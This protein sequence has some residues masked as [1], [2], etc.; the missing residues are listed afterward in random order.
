MTYHKPLLATVVMTLAGG[1]LPLTVLAEQSP[2]FD[3]YGSVRTQVESVQPDNENALGAYEGLRDAYSR[4]G[5][6]ADY[7]ISD[8]LTIFGQVEIPLDTASLRVRDPYDQG[9]YGRSQGER[10]RLGQIGLRGNL[11]T[12]A[13]GQ[14]WMPYYNAIAAT[15]DR[16]STYYS[17][18]ATYTAFRVRNTLAYYS[19]IWQGFAFA[20]SYSG[21]DGNRRSTSRI[22]DRRIQF[23]TT[24]VFG[25]TQLAAGVDDRGDAGNQRNRIYGLSAAQQIG[26][27]HLAAKY[28]IFDT[29]NTSSGQFNSDGNQ[30][31]NL[32]ASYALGKNTFK[33]MLARVENYGDNIVHFG[34]DH[35]YQDDL[36]FFAEYYREQETAALTIKQ[37]GLDGFNAAA[38]GGQVFA[39]GLRYDF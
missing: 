31:V 4:L 11:G 33:L 10:F 23:T 9:G 37:G 39:A 34:V 12:L 20:A 35:Q 24:Y 30:A 19:P 1:T 22:D 14:Q 16:F 28:E 8:G 32:F 38:G 17:G 29:A 2:K 6:K 18:F 5:I 21:A 36:K 7:A 3:F 27:L 15:T 26:S 13:Y 25:N